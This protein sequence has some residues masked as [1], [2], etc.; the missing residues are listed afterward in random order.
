M[1]ETGK[2]FLF[3]LT[4]Q[5]KIDKMEGEKGIDIGVIQDFPEETPGH[6]E[7]EHEL[8]SKPIVSRKAIVLRTLI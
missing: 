8:I 3:I 1:F 4:K 6:E 2:H 5:E 7:G